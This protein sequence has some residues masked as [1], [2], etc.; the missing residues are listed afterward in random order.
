MRNNLNKKN[1]FTIIE[2]LVVISIIG[3]ITVVSAYS[4]NIIRIKARDTKRL[5][6]LKAMYNALQLYY[7]NYGVF[8]GDICPPEANPGN[9]DDDDYYIND[10]CNNSGL[11]IF[12]TWGDNCGDF[13]MRKFSD[14]FN[15]YPG[16]KEYINE[17][18]KDP[19]ASSEHCYL[20][21]PSNYG[22]SF[23]VSMMPERLE[24]NCNIANYCIKVNK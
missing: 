6:D 22:Q 5:A 13:V 2:L 10:D 18:P 1:G 24:P 14:L 4:V 17:F 16:L 15:N 11:T 20:Y 9:P 8:P 19:L 23:T 12:L 3:L 21:H 7:D